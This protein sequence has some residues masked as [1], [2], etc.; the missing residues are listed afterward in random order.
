MVNTM[1]NKTYKTSEMILIVRLLMLPRP[2]RLCIAFGLT[3]YA[4]YA[5]H[6]ICGASTAG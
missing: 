3:L 4:E 1:T 2:F 5:D 6:D